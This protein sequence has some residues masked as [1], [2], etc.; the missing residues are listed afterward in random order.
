M[1][2]L[3][4]T[5]LAAAASAP[6]IILDFQ[7]QAVDLSGSNQGDYVP[8]LAFSRTNGLNQQASLQ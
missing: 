6:L 4:F 8:I 3:N 1:V 2:H 5:A 7:G